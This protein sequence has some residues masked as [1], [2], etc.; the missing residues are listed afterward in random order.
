MWVFSKKKIWL[1]AFGIFWTVLAFDEF[2]YKLHLAEFHNFSF[3]PRRFVAKT[4]DS[5]HF[6]ANGAKTELKS[7]QQELKDGIIPNVLIPFNIAHYCSVDKYRLIHNN[8]STNFMYLP[9]NLLSCWFLWFISSTSRK[10]PD[11]LQNKIKT[12]TEFHIFF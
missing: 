7:F 3:F 10:E 9:D 6:F 1:L 12:F 2:P 11:N 5:D 4:E 8:I